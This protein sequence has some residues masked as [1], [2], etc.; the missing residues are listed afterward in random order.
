LVVDFGV[1]DGKRTTY[2]FK[3]RVDAELMAQK[4]RIERN[5]IGSDALRLNEDQKK[6]PSLPAI[7]LMGA[8]P[9]WTTRLKPFCK[10][11]RK[12]V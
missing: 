5:K 11:R 7:S 4:K 6:K 10:I 1:V 3:S 9:L 12:M 2:T 8:L